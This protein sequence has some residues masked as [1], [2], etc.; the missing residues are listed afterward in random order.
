VIGI[1]QTI[2]SISNSKGRP[3]IFIPLSFVVI[4]SMVKDLLEDVRRRVSDGKENMQKAVVFR[5]G[6]F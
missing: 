1:L 6:R 3:V 5:K 2:K 4:V